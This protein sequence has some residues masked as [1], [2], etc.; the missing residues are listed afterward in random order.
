MK[1]NEKNKK[2]KR[3]QKWYKGIKR[4]RKVEGNGRKERGV[5]RSAPRSANCKIDETDSSARG[6]F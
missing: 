1:R 5:D 6:I 4:N 3:I 2:K